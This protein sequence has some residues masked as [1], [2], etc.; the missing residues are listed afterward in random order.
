MS[1]EIENCGLECSAIL[2]IQKHG[3]DGWDYAF[4]EYCDNCPQIEHCNVVNGTVEITPKG[5][6]LMEKILA[7]DDPMSEFKKAMIEA[8]PVL[9]NNPKE[10]G[11]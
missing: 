1:K 2:Y 8:K 11:K 3:I 9:S 6:K 10:E 7:S 4:G 5:I